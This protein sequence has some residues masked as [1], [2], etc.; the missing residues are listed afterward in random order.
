MGDIYENIEEYNSD[1]KRKVLLV[2]NVIN[3]DMLGNKK[4]NPIVTDLFTNH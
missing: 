3:A 1:K 2:V 4:I